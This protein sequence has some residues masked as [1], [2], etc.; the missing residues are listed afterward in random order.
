MEQ[1]PIH[2][3]SSYGSPDPITRNKDKFGR[4]RFFAEMEIVLLELRGKGKHFIDENQKFTIETDDES[5]LDCPATLCD[6]DDENL[7]V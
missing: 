5:R 2:C 4:L 3:F 7:C 1:S 6:G